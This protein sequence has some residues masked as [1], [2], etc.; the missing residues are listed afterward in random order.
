LKNFFKY[1][2]TALLL[3]GLPLNNAFSQN[4]SGGYDA[5]YFQSDFI[6]ELSDWSSSLVN[7]ALLYRINQE[8]FGIGMYRW[9]IGAE[10]LGFQTAS[11]LHPIRRNQ[12]VGVTVINA[13]GTIA[14]SEIENGGIRNTGNFLRY[15]DWWFV[16]SYA[17]R[18]PGAPWLVVGSNVKYRVQNQ[19][20]EGVSF[21]KNYIPAVDVGIYLNPMDH[22]RFGDLGFSLN[23][24]DV[25]PSKF[26]W[27]TENESPT[28][29]LT[30]SRFRSGIRYSAFNDKMVIDGEI[31][32]DNAFSDIQ[33][34]IGLIEEAINSEGDTLLQ[35]A[36]QLKKALRPGFHFKY[37]FHP[38]IWFKAGWTNN[39]IPYVG[40]NFNTIYPLPEMINYLNIDYH[41]GYSFIEN[42]LKED[43]D[44]GEDERQFTMM[45]K[46][47][48]DFGKTR[49][50]RESRR[51]YDRLILAPMD[52]YQEAMRLFFEGRYWEAGF[53]FGKVIALF[54]NFHLN[55]KATFYMGESYRNIHLNGIAR[56]IY[57]EAL[58]EYTTSEM[59]AKYLYGLQ[60]IDYREGKYDDALKNHAFITNLFPDHEIRPD[61]DY[62][63][64][65]IHFE[66]KNFN[67]AEKLFKQV[68]PD[69][70]SYPY[71]QYTL[72]IINYETDREAAAIAN[73]QTVINDTSTSMSIQLLQDAANLK[74]G[75]IYF[76]S[77]DKLKE[78]V[79]AYQRVPEGSVYGDE[80]LLAIAWS[81]IK[82]D[83]PDIALRAV[84]Q[85][86]SIHPNSPLVPEAYLVMGYANMLLKQYQRAAR[87]LQRCIE[88]TKKDFV[89]EQDLTYRRRQF[90]KYVQD[91]IPTAQRIKKNAFRKPT[92]TTLSERPELESEFEKF[93]SESRQFFEYTLLAKNH[94]KF[95]R[96]KE[97]LINDAEFALAKATKMMKSRKTTEII[98]EQREEQQEIESD[99]ERI[100]RELEELEQ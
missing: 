50:Q 5:P 16:G 54:P 67:V 8:Y 13:G 78:A 32:I 73:L 81:W 48:S 96:R 83:Q 77:G 41:L 18:F 91:F 82:V 63:A 79:V 29:Q 59:R 34:A 69:A 42:I 17:V 43:Q 45:F 53:A 4:A 26:E 46:L 57:K 99:I 38:A 52:A 85:L 90:Q 9:G 14:Q 6:Q 92:E 7:P 64:G 1:V 70:P 22:Y 88:L 75:H 58:E 40:L 44:P 80:A 97:E 36:T 76:E 95:F 72:A 60:N 74:L 10:A 71:A 65:Q 12:T 87:A 56:E 2:T 31:V 23:F 39:N 19:F 68:T 66:R 100:Q 98:Q 33:N 30:V 15:G 24:V 89:T 25:V 51:M 35:T 86:I 28:E 55:D 27:G 3:A 49:E 11:F 20:D 47:S 93:A 94:K 61:A 37:E 84:G 21:N 62:L